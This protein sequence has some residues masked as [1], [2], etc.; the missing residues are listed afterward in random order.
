MA[1]IQKTDLEQEEKFGE[2]DYTQIDFT[3]QKVLAIFYIKTTNHF[4]K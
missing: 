4:I 2:K 1:K 3:T